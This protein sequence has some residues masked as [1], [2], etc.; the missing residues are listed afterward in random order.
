MEVTFAA[1]AAACRCLDLG[2]TAVTGS[3]RDVYAFTDT[4]E[5]ELASRCA[6]YA[7]SVKARVG[8]KAK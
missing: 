8:G 6:R 4:H 3:L 1:Y 5:I 7:P 2:D